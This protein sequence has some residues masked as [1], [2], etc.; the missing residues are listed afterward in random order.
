VLLARAWLVAGLDRLDSTR[1]GL[2]ASQVK[3]LAQ[4]YNNPSRVSST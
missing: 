2:L 1:L 3:I 4:Q